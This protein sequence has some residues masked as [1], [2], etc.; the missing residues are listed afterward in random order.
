MLLEMVKSSSSYWP[1][2]LEKRLLFVLLFV[3]AINISSRT[4]PFDFVSL[5]SLIVGCPMPEKL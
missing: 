3:F 1:W 4:Y 2:T 5:N